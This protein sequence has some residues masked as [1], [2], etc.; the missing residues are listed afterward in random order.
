MRIA[1]LGP[2]GTF[3][4]KAYE[5]Y[6]RDKSLEPVYYPTIDDVFEA[7]C[8]EDCNEEALCTYGIVPIEN[9]L[10][11][12]VLRTLDCLLEREVCIL[13]ENMVEVQF[14]LVGNVVSKEEIETLYVQFKANGQCR[15]FISSLNNVKICTTESNME[16]YFRIADHKGEAAVVPKHIADRE[17]ERFVI[18]NI[19]D[20]NNNHTRFVIFKRGNVDGKTVKEIIPS[21]EMEACCEKNLKV[22]IPVYIMPKEDKPGILYN[23][24]KEFYD[25]QINLISIMSRPTKQEI[26]TYNFYIEIDGLYNR[27]DAIMATLNRIKEYNE[28]KILGIYSE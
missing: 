19:T 3:S 10:D 21:L 27:I 9:T 23:I 5:E 11:G 22:R 2:E 17:Q 7:V 25:N 4:D 12:Y 18:D 26:G 15:R 6:N 1:V 20:T 16:S 13:D 8:P 14:S 24:L 28:I